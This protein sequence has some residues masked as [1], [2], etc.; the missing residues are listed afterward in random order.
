MCVCVR[1]S[2]SSM[3][4]CVCASPS[5]LDDVRVSEQFEVLDLSF[6]LPHHVQAADLLPVEDFHG[7]FVSRQ[8]MLADCSAP[9]DTR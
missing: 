8:L 1:L 4:V 2:H 3:C 6:D 9:H 5:Q 7:H